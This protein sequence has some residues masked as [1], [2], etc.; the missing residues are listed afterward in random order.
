M[1]LTDR[2]FLTGACGVPGKSQNPTIFC[3]GGPLVPIVQTLAESV[4]GT[5]NYPPFRCS[6]KKQVFILTLDFLLG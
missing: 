3:Q 2:F 1:Y 6:A 5:N 4:S